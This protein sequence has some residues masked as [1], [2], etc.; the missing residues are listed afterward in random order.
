MACERKTLSERRG[1]G[2]AAT[3][4]IVRSDNP[5]SR[6][7]ARWRR[8]AAA[9]AAV[10]V[11]LAV[12]SSAPARAAPEG[13]LTWAVHV[14]LPATW[15]DPGE[16]PTLITPTMVMYALHD[17][18]V[19]PMPGKMLGEGLAE[20]W[21]AS[22]DGL[23]YEFVLR[24]GLKFHNGDDVTSEDV[25]FTFERYKGGLYSEL[26][27]AVASVET[28]DPLRVQFKLKK[29]WPD[30]MTYYSTASFAN[31]IVPKKYVEQ[32][33]VENYKKAP[34][35]AGPYK[36]VSFTPGVELVLE[37]H[38][39][40]WRKQPKVKR[41][42]FKTIPD[43][44][45]RLAALKRGE[46]DI[47]Y[48]IR[49]ELGAELEK[50]KG[51]SLKSTVIAAPF[52]LYFAD[53]WDPKSPWNDIRVRQAAA[54]AVDYNGINDALA[55]GHSRITGSIIPDMFEFYWQPPKPVYDPAKAKK[56]LAEAGYPNGFDAGDYHVDSS[57]ANV[58]ETVVN[59]LQAVGIRVRMRPVERVALFKAYSERTLK[60][61]IQ[62]GSGAFG[63]AATR[64]ETFVV[65]GGPY[66][67]GNYP[68]IDEMFR[69][70]AIELD[71]KKREATLHKI[72]QLVVERHIYLPIWQLAF[73]NGLGPRVEESGLGLI[74]GHPYSAP[75]DDIAIKA[76]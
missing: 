1:I 65:K 47:A 16:T 67:Y 73:I 31:W 43:E 38:E 2:R 15:F 34:I 68:D 20:S 66:V 24:K 60:N 61:V 5:P 14:S 45:T 4:C 19:K 41:L 27:Q 70:Q 21:S 59:N 22:Q 64:L 54:L 74:A 11:A 48:S 75:Y 13:Q 12:G 50:T 32:V 69:E 28:P 53:Q 8:P 62:G 39:Q 42:V 44:A 52:W 6:S 40:Y 17:A 35:G 33:G 56:L 71:T 18:L 36:F 9:L 58:G 26:K 29:P 51:L 30:F 46:V 23:T 49:G 57:Y 76:K 37:A 72:Q 7:A 25:K 63:S 55:L 3:A 10:V